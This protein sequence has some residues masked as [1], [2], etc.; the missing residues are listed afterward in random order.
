MRAR[1]VARKK[2]KPR[3]ERG[4]DRPDRGGGTT[5]GIGKTRSSDLNLSACLL[6]DTA[7]QR[8]RVVAARPSAGPVMNSTPAPR[9]INHLTA[10]L[11][12]IACTRGMISAVGSS[13]VSYSQSLRRPQLPT[14]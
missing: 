2:K 5:W 4:F 11:S 12:R 9:R 6:C 7:A 8:R 3:D 1:H 10:R 14:P 13:P